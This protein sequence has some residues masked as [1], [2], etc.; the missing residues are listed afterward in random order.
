MSS[1]L[2]QISGFGFRISGTARLRP[3][4]LS[5]V[6]DD[7]QKY[8]WLAA[9]FARRLPSGLG[10]NQPVPEKSILANPLQVSRHRTGV[11]APEPHQA[12]GA[13]E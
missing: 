4:A 2:F 10:A 13:A 11:E 6:R 5:A 9:S 1:D 12:G 3:S 8:I 7:G